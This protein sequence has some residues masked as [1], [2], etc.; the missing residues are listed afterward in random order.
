MQKIGRVIAVSTAALLPI[1]LVVA[2]GL[3]G[4]TALMG[5]PVMGLKLSF[6]DDGIR[7]TYVDEDGPVA[8]LILPGDYLRAIGNV[9]LVQEDILRYPEFVRRADERSWW[10]RQQAIYEELTTARPLTLGV[11]SP[12]KLERRI[13]I[14]PIH[15]T[16]RDIVVRGFPIF[17]SG[18]VL[19]GMSAVMYRRSRSPLHRVSAVFFLSLGLYHMATA[20]M[21]MREIVLGRPWGPGF[22]Y[23]AFLAAGGCISLVHFAM[24]FPRRKRIL[25]AHP[26]LIWIL[27]G[28]FGLTAVL[29]LGGITAFGSTYLCLL[30]WAG[31]VVVATLHTYWTEEDLL[32][33]QQVL[34]FLMIPVLIVLFLC[35]Y[36]ILPSVLRTNAFEYSYFAIL[37][38]ASVFS[39]ALAV[40]NQRIYQEALEKEQADLRD[41]TRL[42]REVHD[43][44]G[45]VLSGIIRLTDNPSASGRN[46]GGGGGSLLGIRT[47]AQ[48]SLAELRSFIEAVD[49]SSTLWS[50]FTGILER[51]AAE[52][53][54]PL[55]IR[56]DFDAQVDPEL[57]F[58]RPL[59]RHH[60]TGILREAL[61]N[62]V[63][64]AQ[65]GRVEMHLAVR[66]GKGQ[67]VIQDDGKGMAAKRFREG[68]HGLLHMKQR[69]Q[70]MDGALGV[71]STEQGT[72]LEIQFEP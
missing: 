50:E 6:S 25:V 41:R 63:K 60:L 32:L 16:L 66:K 72:R 58:V 38:V 43:N 28:Y 10:T 59:V 69:A 22:A 65:A 55:N 53:L 57:E 68:A 36:I 70:E 13:Q 18:A 33:K 47:A 35:M 8:G 7:V 26:R 4:V 19:G 15:R 64:H 54:H 2:M 40:E 21:T 24:I 14:E 51:R 5:V 62:I 49:P 46:A 17:L 44:F 71:Q 20:P 39:M 45:N 56:L 1:L 52:L 27:Y 42:V 23:A 30:F 11:A 31:L 61:G 9:K 48:H 12:G 37:T 29:Y 67:M 34:L 3:A